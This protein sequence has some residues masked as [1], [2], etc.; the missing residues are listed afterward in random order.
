VLVPKV[1]FISAPGW[2]PPDV[3]RRGGPQA[4]VTGKAI[5]AWQKEKRRFRL[6]SVHPG[7]TADE[8]R[9]NTGF[10]YDDRNQ[11]AVTP[12]PA[13]EELKLLRGPV[14]AR[15]AENYPAFAQRVWKI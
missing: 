7:G 5:F 6:E 12:A 8:V 14:A 13:D 15:I 4:L 10:D 3:W 11:S 9:E 2:S 1:D